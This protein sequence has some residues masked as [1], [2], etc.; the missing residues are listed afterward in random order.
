MPKTEVDLVALEDRALR[1]A[2]NHSNVR[3]TVME[4]FE[5]VKSAYGTPVKKAK[6]KKP[7]A[8]IGELTDDDDTQ[9]PDAE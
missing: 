1:A 9:V 2:N 5:L 4:L 6:A 3:A 8:T 7:K